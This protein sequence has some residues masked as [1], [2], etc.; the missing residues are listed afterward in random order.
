[1][2]VCWAAIAIKEVQMCFARQ[3]SVPSHACNPHDDLR[4]PEINRQLPNGINFL[5]LAVFFRVIGLTRLL[6][7]G[8][9]LPPFDAHAPDHEPQWE[10]QLPDK[11]ELADRRKTRG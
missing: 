7:E 4:G 5:K 10:Q 3:N 8:D 2:F 9:F 11:G 6:R 1:M